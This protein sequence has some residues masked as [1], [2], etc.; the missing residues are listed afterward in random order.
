MGAHA[1]AAK[2]MLWGWRGCNAV[3]EGSKQQRNSPQRLTFP[4][5]LVCRRAQ[6]LAEVCR[7]ANW[8]KAQGV[9]KGDSVAI[10]M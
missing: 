2:H 4:L 10:Y 9:K 7:V 3:K 5:P 6:V 8:L 1:R